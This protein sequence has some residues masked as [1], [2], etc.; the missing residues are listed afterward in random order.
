MNLKLLLQMRGPAWIAA[1]RNQNNAVAARTALAQP[2]GPIPETIY[3]GMPGGSNGQNVQ[4]QPGGRS[5]E[6]EMLLHAAGL[7]DDETQLSPSLRESQL[8]IGRGRERSQSPP[9]EDV[10]PPVRLRRA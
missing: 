1:F 9:A 6:V 7:G 3:D 5:N 10:R 8:H 2:D 4:V